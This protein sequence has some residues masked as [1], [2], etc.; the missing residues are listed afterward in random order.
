MRGCRQTASEISKKSK[1][2]V[3]E[4]PIYDAR[5]AVTD[6]SRSS[7]CYELLKRQKAASSHTTKHVSS[8]RAIHSRCCWDEV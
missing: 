1:A 5:C 7:K 8:E 3:V 6:A 2:V 4:F